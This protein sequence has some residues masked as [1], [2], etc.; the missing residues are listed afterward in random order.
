[1]EVITINYGIVSKGYV[2]RDNGKTVLVDAGLYYDQPGW[3]FNLVMSGVMP[4]EIDLIVLTH[5]HF[6]HA[7]GI[8]HAKTLTGAKLLAH[9]GAKRFIETGEFDPYVARNELGQAFIDQ[10]ANPAPLDVPECVEIDYPVCEDCDLHEMG[11]NARVLMTPGHTSDSISLVYD[12]GETFAGDTILDPFGQGICTY[13]VICPDKDA[14]VASAKKL[15]DAGAK[16]YYSGH[17]GPFTREQ[18]E[19][20]FKN[21]VETNN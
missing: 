2:I 1:M 21:L 3:L 11:I 6:D 7:A 5:G 20:A 15:L 8:H 17:G 18:A 19:E 16:T 10:I 12:S 9:V 4:N 13:A 14:L